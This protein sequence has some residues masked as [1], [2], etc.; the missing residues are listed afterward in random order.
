MKQREIQLVLINSQNLI[1]KANLLVIISPHLTP[2]S[3]S[4]TQTLT[5]P[6]N[7]A[8][9][10]TIGFVISATIPILLP[11]FL[12]A[13]IA[14][15]MNVTVSSVFVGVHTL[16]LS[17]DMHLVFLLHVVPLHHGLT[18]TTIRIKLIMN[19]KL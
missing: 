18:P 8:T 19:L 17:V 15:N 11:V 4:I 2:V 1:P 16:N 6:L 12:H 10:V 5:I 13:N 7:L 14:V 9:M 3:L